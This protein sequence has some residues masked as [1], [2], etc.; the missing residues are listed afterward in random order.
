MQ[1]HLYHYS[2]SHLLVYMGVSFKL[3]VC[4]SATFDARSFTSSVEGYMKQYLL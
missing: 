3:F 1:Y 4:T 2:A